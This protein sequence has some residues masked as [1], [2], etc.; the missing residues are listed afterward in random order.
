[1][2]AIQ[3]IKEKLEEIK[4]LDKGFS[5]FGSHG[6]QYRMG[7]TLT[8]DELAQIETE[9]Q[10]V[11]SNDYKLILTQLGNGGA[12]CGYGLEKLSLQH[13]Q[14]PYPGCDYLLRNWDDPSKVR[15][16]MVDIDEISGYIKLFD[17]GCGMEYCLVVNGPEQKELIFFDCDGRF[18]KTNGMTLLDIY[19]RWLDEGIK[20]LRRVKKKLS[21][22]PTEEV[23]DSEWKLKNYDVKKMITSVKK[24]DPSIGVRSGNDM[25]GR[26]QT[27]HKKRR[28]PD[29]PKK[30]SWL[31]I[32]KRRS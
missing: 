29:L 21:Q 18:E 9:N 6:H 14:P 10:I 7:P 1:M 19:E 30:K 5:I 16:D 15:T 11:L 13:I 3:V 20:A 25:S 26:V 32:F 2:E 27:D 28:H 17:Y 22:M 23:I 4:R 8:M 31:S 12:G 24:G